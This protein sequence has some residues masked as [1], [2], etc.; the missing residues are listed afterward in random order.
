[1][2]KANIANFKDHLSDYLDKVQAGNVVEICKRNVPVAVVTPVGSPHENRTVPG[3]G[4]NTV[5]VHVDLTEPVF[6]SD[7]DMLGSDERPA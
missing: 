4:A 5:R 3:C 7:W 6:E 1:M 2:I